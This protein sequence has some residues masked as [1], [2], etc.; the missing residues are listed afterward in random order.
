MSRRLPGG[1]D[2]RAETW[3]RRRRLQGQELEQEGA[4][5]VGREGAGKRFPPHTPGV[6][7]FLPLL[8]TRRDG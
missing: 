8:P 3:R 1:G 4:V 6:C 7:D 2:L 5:R